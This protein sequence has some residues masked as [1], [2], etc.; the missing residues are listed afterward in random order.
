[1]TTQS[2]AL[3]QFAGAYLH[4]DW[5]EVHGD[6]WGALDAFINDEPRLAQQLPD[7]IDSLLRRFTT[8]AQLDTFF[9]GLGSAFLPDPEAGGYHAW[10]EEVA[11]RARRASTR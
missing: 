5:P 10:L 2:P 1:M 6:E 9:E 3:W 7:E 8:E 4:E 11:A